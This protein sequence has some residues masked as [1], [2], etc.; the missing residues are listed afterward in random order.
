MMSDTKQIGVVIVSYNTCA[1]LSDCLDSLRASGQRLSIVVVDNGSSDGSQAMLA[2]QSDLTL[3][4]AG[5]N[6]GFGAANNLGWRYLASQAGGLPEFVLFLNPDTKLQPLALERLVAFLQAHPR[7]GVVGPRLLNADGSLQRAAFRFP[8]LSMALFDLF[9]PG[10]VTPGRFYDSWWHGRYADEALNQNEPFA[11][12]HPLGACMLTRRE[13]LEEVGGFDERYFMYS[14]EVEWCWRIRAAG[15]A[16]WQQPQAEVI[17]Y[18]GASTS[19]FRHR[20]FVELYRSRFQF[21]RDYRSRA[22]QAAYRAIV[23]L[24]LLRLLLQAWRSYW[25]KQIDRAELRAR[26][27]AYG[28]IFVLGR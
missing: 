11:I 13:L 14:D 8:S 1:L 20:M 2:A 27:W 25:R 12:D 5:K 23:R 16:I 15:W 6:L 7:V 18:G 4:E 9:P 3:L 19:Q 17:H 22:Y 21:A 24:G 26:L 10:E 28:R